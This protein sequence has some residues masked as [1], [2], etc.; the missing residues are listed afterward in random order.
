MLRCDWVLSSQSAPTCSL[1]IARCV[2]QEN[3]VVQ[4]T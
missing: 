3:G 1:K 2:L 4:A